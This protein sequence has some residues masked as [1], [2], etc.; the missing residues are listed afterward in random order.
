[1][2]AAMRATYPDVFA[3][4]AVIAGLPFGVAG[5][6]PEA[7]DRMRGHG[8][9]PAAAL[10]N[11]VGQHRHRAR[12]GRS[13]RFGT[14]VP[15]RR[16][17]EAG[18]DV[19]D[20]YVIRGLGHGTPLDTRRSGHGEKAA[21]FMLEAGISSTQFIARFWGIVPLEA[22]EDDVGAPAPASLWKAAEERRP[23]TNYNAE[24]GIRATIEGALR[25][26]GL[27]K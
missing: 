21:P 17:D 27:M 25:Q 1:M 12:I 18:R 20:E 9:P 19:I 26:A 13:C 15:I 16:E 2:A 22:E 24:A 10:S 3:G 6:V 4:G 11:L 7:F 8:G 23:A 14:A 5:S